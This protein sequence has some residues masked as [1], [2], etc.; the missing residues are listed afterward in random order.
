MKSKTSFFWRIHQLFFCF[1]LSI[2]VLT[3]FAFTGHWVAGFLMMSLPVVVVIHL[4]LCIFWFIYWPQK[5]LLSACALLLSFPFWARTGH[6]TSAKKFTEKVPKEL[7]V[8][9]Y[10]VM[11][12]DVLRYLDRS[13]PQNALDLLAWAKDTE[14]DVKCFQEFYNLDTRPDFNTLQQFKKV[15]YKHYTVL[16]P[17][18]AKYE[19]HFFGL[20]ILSKYPIVKRGEMEF[21]DQNGMLFADIK[22]GTDTIRVINVHLRSLIVRFGKLKEAYQ[23]KNYQQGKSESRKVFERIKYGFV[24]HAQETQWLCQ[25]I[26][27]SPYPVL[28]CGDFNETPYGYVYGQVRKRLSNAFEEVGSGFGFSY[29]NAPKFIRIDNQFFDP[30]ITTFGV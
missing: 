27:Q 5:S 20:A 21:Q 2:Y 29:Q 4:L 7:K 10:N 3:Y 12:F 26:D 28:L 8:L 19:K 23:E 16:H 25:W 11:S 9:S 14:A 6:F 24:N 17:K 22:I 30:K 1:T 18:I 15:G 13:D